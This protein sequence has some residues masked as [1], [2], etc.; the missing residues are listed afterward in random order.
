MKLLVGGFLYKA[1]KHQ[2][3]SAVVEVP[4]NYSSLEDSSND[5]KQ[6][7][8]IVGEQC[9]WVDAGQLRHGGVITAISELK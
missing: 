2:G 3:V 5:F 8:E 4:E 7:R 6:L 1:G 9:K